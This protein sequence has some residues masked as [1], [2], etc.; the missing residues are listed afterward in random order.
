MHAS[1]MFTLWKKKEVRN[2]RTNVLHLILID[3]FK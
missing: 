2:K 1:N 3:N